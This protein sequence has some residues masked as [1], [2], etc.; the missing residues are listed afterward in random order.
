MDRVDSCH[1]N[2]NSTD[3]AQRP[4]LAADACD[5]LARIGNALT[6]DAKGTGSTSLLGALAATP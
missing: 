3:P 1:V 6:L 2:I 5:E 4:A